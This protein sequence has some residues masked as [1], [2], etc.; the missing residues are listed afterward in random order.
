MT[1]AQAKA[2]VEAAEKAWVSASLGR[3]DIPQHVVDELE[4]AWREEKELSKKALTT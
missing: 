1:K 4:A 2:R 3:E